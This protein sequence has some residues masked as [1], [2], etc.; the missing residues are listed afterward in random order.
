MTSEIKQLKFVLRS[1]ELRRETAEKELAEAFAERL[2]SQVSGRDG[3]ELGLIIA[4]RIVKD[5]LK[6]AECL[7]QR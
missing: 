1:L 7:I 6:R 3:I 4:I 2:W 5:E